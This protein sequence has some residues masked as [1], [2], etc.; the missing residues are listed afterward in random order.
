MIEHAGMIS[1]RF[2]CNR[3]FTHEMVRMRLCSFAQESTRYVDYKK[4]NDIKFIIPPLVNLFKDFNFEVWKN[5]MINAEESYFALRESGW[6][7]QL[8]T[9]IVVTANLR[10]WYHVFK[11][12]TDSKAHPSMQELMQPLLHEFKDQIPVIFDD[13]PTYLTFA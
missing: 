8:K 10:E 4:Q 9:E 13:L 11:L 3:G 6:P 12:R 7:P 2:I 1:V 5:A